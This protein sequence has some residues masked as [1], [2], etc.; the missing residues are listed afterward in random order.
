MWGEADREAVVFDVDCLSLPLSLTD[1][2]QR[3]LNTLKFTKA[4]IE[5]PLSVHVEVKKYYPLERFS[6]SV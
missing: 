5:L 2:F 4:T 3:K 6:Y 1:L